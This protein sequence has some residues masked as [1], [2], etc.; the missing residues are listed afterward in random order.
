MPGFD[1]TGPAGRGAMT[2]RGL[3]YC[4]PKR[5]SRSDEEMSPEPDQIRSDIDAPDQRPVFGLGRG[6]LPRGGGRG[7]GR[8]RM[9]R[10]W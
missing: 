5:A 8:G 10:F 6:G 7:F 1:R 9:C 3:G 4:N 2:G